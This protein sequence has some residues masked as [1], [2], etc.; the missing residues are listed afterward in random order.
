M[1][2]VAVCIAVRGVQANTFRSALP[3]GE[4]KAQRLP[5]WPMLL[6]RP[7]SVRHPVREHRAE[8]LEE[9]ASQRSVWCESFVNHPVRR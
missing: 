7:D 8:G 6:Y 5:E 1:E 4:R 3:I 2:S 9:P